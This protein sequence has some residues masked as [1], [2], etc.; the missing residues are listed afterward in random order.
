MWKWKLFHADFLV[1]SGIF[2]YLTHVA[3]QWCT[4][5]VRNPLCGSGS[6]CQLQMGSRIGCPGVYL[7]ACSKKGLF[8]I[9]PLQC[10]FQ[11]P[12]WRLLLLNAAGKVVSVRISSSTSVRATLCCSSHLNDSFLLTPL[13]LTTVSLGVCSNRCMMMRGR[14]GPS[15]SSLPYLYPHQQ[16]SSSLFPRFS[17]FSVILLLQSSTLIWILLLHALVFHV[18]LFSVPFTL[19]LIPL[20]SDSNL[21]NLLLIQLNCMA[22][23]AG[24][25]L[26]VSVGLGSS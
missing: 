24:V 11:F 3:E 14:W 16:F 10:G 5:H 17:V 1:L 25:R 6:P 12:C 15:L 21:Y 23:V 20:L 7:Q 2:R 22:S 19:S 4:G 18:P 13:V 26:P 8:S 9:G